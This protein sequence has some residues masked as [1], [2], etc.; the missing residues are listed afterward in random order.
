MARAADIKALPIST[1][2]IVSNQWQ[3]VKKLGEGGFGAVYEAKNI[4]NPNQ[5]GAMK[6]EP[7]GSFK[8]DEVLKMEAHVLKALCKAKHSCKLFATGKTP[9]YNYLVMTLLGKSL[10]DLRRDA[11]DQKFSRGTVVHIGLECLE[12]IEELH[13]VGFLHRDI[14]PSNFAIGRKKQQ[15]RTLYIYDFGLARQY[16]ISGELLIYSLWFKKYYNF[17]KWQSSTS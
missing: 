5:M 1:G 11:P 10:G 14:K 3:I 17:R 7:F 9:K 8:D 15:Q 6:A 2:T 13:K 16:L 4:R 12:A